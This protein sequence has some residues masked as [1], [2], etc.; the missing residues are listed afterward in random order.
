MRCNAVTDSELLMEGQPSAVGFSC[1]YL[2]GSRISRADFRFAERLAT[3]HHADGSS[4]T[5]VWDERVPMDVYTQ[6][7]GVGLSPD[8]RFLFVPS[9]EKG[10]TCLNAEDGRILWEFRK[11]HAR[12]VF[13]Y[14]EYLVCFFEGEAL[15]RISYAGE[16]LQ[17][18][19]FTGDSADCW[20]LADGPLFMGPKRRRFMLLHPEDF[21]VM[22]TFPQKAV[23]GTEDDPFL[24]WNVSGTS[25]AITLHCWHNDTRI[26][27]ELCPDDAGNK[28]AEGAA[29]R[30]F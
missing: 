20:M 3:L 9:W 17:R 22:N 12:Q 24:V 5:I 15:R 25:D 16:A 14:D 4:R 8:G 28:E 10:I 21:S 23:T 7:Y 30:I 19:P 29:R 13:C 11:K 1:R 2:P 18:L 6:V 26:M 27:R